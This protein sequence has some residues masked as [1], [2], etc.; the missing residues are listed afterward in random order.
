MILG[1]LRELRAG[2]PR[3]VGQSKYLRQLKDV[4]PGDFF[5]CIVKVGVEVSAALASPRLLWLSAL[6]VASA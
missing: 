5:D 6:Q 4:R 2:L 3:G 1:A